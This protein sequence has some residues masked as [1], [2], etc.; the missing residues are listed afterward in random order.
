MNYITTNGVFEFL[1][2][3]SCGN[4]RKMDEIRNFLKKLIFKSKKIAKKSDN[5]KI[6]KL[7]KILKF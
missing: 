5:K 4:F 3:G 6:K 1:F 7:R 2:I